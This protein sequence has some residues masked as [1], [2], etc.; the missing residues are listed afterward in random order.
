MSKER[1]NPVEEN[2]VALLVSYSWGAL[3]FDG[4][5]GELAERDW[6]SCVETL[7]IRA[8]IRLTRRMLREASVIVHVDCDPL[9]AVHISNGTLS[10]PKPI[11]LQMDGV[12][13]YAN[14]FLNPRVGI[15]S[16]P[17][18][19]VLA[20]GLHDRAILRA[21]R[22][23]AAATGLPRLAGFAD[24][25]KACCGHD[26]PQGILVAAANQPAFTSGARIRLLASLAKI[27]DEAAGLS[28][29][30]RWRIGRRIARELG[31]KNDSC[32]LA[33]SLASVRA[34]ITSASTLAVE[35]MMAHK[36]TA[37]LHPHPWPLWIPC[38][39][40]YD[41]DSSSRFSQDRATMEALQG[42]DTSANAAA[43]ES[44]A[45]IFGN[46]EQFKADSIHELFNAVLN[47]N[48]EMM[49]IQERI[50]RSYQCRQ[51]AKRVARLIECV[52][53]MNQSTPRTTRKD[54]GVPEPHGGIIEVFDAL[55]KQGATKIAVVASRAP[56]PEHVSLA[57]HRSDQIESFVVIGNPNGASLLGIKAYGLDQVESLV[58]S[59]TRLVIAPQEDCSMVVATRSLRSSGIHAVVSL[60]SSSIE[61][62]DG[63][64][65]QASVTNEHAQV[66]TILE[67]GLLCGAHSCSVDQILDGQRP[68]M[69]VLKGDESD[70]EIYQRSRDWRNAGTIVRSLRWCDA[71]LSSPERFASMVAEL[72]G[73]EYAI[74]GGGIHTHRLLT[75]S[76]V[77]NL[78]CMILDDG[79]ADS[80]MFKNIPVVHP[81][82]ARASEP[83]VVILSSLTH[84]LAMWKRSARLRQSGVRVLPLYTSAGNLESQTT[85]AR[86]EI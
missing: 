34:V 76:A 39:W 64:I 80:E 51:P 57:E 12:L 75:Y 68:A 83:R 40:R 27:K 26:D 1:S 46:T 21:L 14:T 85:E 66:R 29:P 56:S 42:K 31:V 9:N 44:I 79:A 28:L 84:E 70:F 52:S 18:D 36:P 60:D 7:Q 71:E 20:S 33:H 16:A 3:H 32:D 25:V 15:R 24:R 50:V 86:I 19:C 11:L 30:I 72:N 38:A 17:V 49:S 45:K 55:Y 59:N 2:R 48:D 73:Q 58:S 77:T 43:A 82:D 74:Y 81:S 22:N 54:I 5:A 47:P 78:P 62:I 13:E 41:G 61:Y 10:T 23:R 67:D 37:I 6:S 63:V 8:P 4:V 69:L 35:S 65:D 53:A